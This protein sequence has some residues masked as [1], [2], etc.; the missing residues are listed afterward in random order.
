MPFGHTKF[1]EA[2]GRNYFMVSKKNSSIHSTIKNLSQLLSIDVTNIN[3][4]QFTKNIK[5]LFEKRILDELD[6]IKISNTGKLTFYSTVFER[7]ELQKYLT[8]PINPKKKRPFN[9]NI[10]ISAHNLEIERGRYSRPI[11]SREERFCKYCK[12][13][14]EDEKHFVLNCP[15]Y[16]N[17]RTKFDCLFEDISNADTFLLSF[18]NPQ[19]LPVMNKTCKFLQECY[20]SRDNF[21]KS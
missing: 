6:R 17:I 1:S 4:G 18:M 15:L 20:N 3:E 14:I 2:R 8:F 21:I 19:A 12:N 5:S 9:K 13:E 10:R 11:V 16:N 7:F